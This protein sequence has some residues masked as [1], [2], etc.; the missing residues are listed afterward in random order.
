MDARKEQTLVG[1][2]VLIA[3]G[4]LVFTIFTLS[5]AFAGSGVTYRA[6]F[7]FAGG[8]ESGAT[9]RYAGGPKVGRVEQLRL[10]PTDSR[11]IEIT[12][13]V[14]KGTP[15]KTDSTI[16]IMSLSPLGE[17]HLEVTPGS[18]QAA[19]APDGALLQS[20][21]YVDFNAITR[22]LN[23]LG[24]KVEDLAT[25]LNARAGELK[26]TVA[27]IND[28]MSE[29]NRANL[30]ASLSHV[31][32][33]LEEDRPHLRASL[34]HVEASTAKL[35]ALLDDFKKT[36]AEAQRALDHADAMITENRPDLHQALQDLRQ[37]LLSANNVT[38]RLDRTLEV[39]SENIDELLENM[40]HATENLKQFTDTI[41]TR[42]A[43]LL[44]SSAPKDRQ[45]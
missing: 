27:R 43:T 40:R 18:S 23:T 38:S 8:L 30:G 34:E 3:A 11:R 4:I 42:P 33:M 29:K 36:V 10:D 41:K 26:E 31:R 19:L 1:L 45:P 21:P 28:V 17:N 35:P 24:P 14:Q 37:A 22:Q 5:G 20:E 25:T 15:V 6:S 32:G 16:R 12:F 7:P 9:V 13:S 2:F 44:R 39:N